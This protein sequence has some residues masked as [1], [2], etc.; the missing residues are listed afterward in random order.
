MCTLVKLFTR[1]LKM[2]NHRISNLPMGDKL[3]FAEKWVTSHI[4]DASQVLGKPVLFTEFGV[5]N[6][7]KNFEFKNRIDMIKMISEKIYESAK[8]NGAGAGALIWQFVVE[9]LNRFQDEFAVIPWQEPLLYDAIIE[10][11]CRLYNVTGNYNPKHSACLK[12][13]T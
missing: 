12:Y 2:L 1:N 4:E 9:D 3:K 11:S 7:V 13:I 10:Q 5:S 8:A 6:Q